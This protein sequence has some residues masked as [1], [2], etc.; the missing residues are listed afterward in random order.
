MGRN[1][2]VRLI[3]VLVVFGFF[4]CSADLF[5]RMEADKTIIHMG[6]EVTVRILAYASETVPG[7]GLNVWQLDMDVAPEY[8][9]VIAVQTDAS[10][11]AMIDLIAPVPYD[12]QASG[13]D[14]SSVNSL[15]SGNLR[16]LGVSTLTAPQVSDTA[17]GGYS[18]LAEVTIVGVVSGTAVCNLTNHL[19]GLGF[20]GILADGTYYDVTS[21]NLHFDAA[22]S[23]NVFT[24][25][26]EPGS[27]LLLTSLGAVILRCRKK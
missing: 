20:Y 26:P 4:N 11:T 27:F 18:V 6:E 22:N 8:N 5:F 1:W 16:Q 24:V 14:H 2:A 12:A 10:G 3:P 23:D 25:M 7:N 9:G 19:L 17:V 15:V 21:G 13:W